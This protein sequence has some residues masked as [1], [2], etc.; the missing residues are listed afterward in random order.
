MKKLILPILALLLLSACGGKTTNGGSETAGDSAEV[1]TEGAAEKKSAISENL[2]TECSEDG[3][4]AFVEAA[5]N[6][7]FHPS[8]EDEEK[9]SEITLFGL[10]Y[11]D[12]YFSD[13]F[14]QAIVDAYD[15][16]IETDDLFFDYS[17]W[18][19][20]QDETDLV[21]KEVI[22]T[23]FSENTAKVEVLFTNGGEESEACVMVEYNK[24][25][26]RWYITNF[27]DPNTGEKLWDQIDAYTSDGLA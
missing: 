22:C 6:N 25:K 16:Q 11:M 5:Y 7:Y 1:A 17:V 2:Q 8:K 3:A 18:T 14:L 15:K 10:A 21:L 23:E 19:N 12:K 27:V 13:D 4:V 26:G 9:E 20:S 24:E